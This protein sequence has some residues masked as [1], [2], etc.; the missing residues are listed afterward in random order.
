MAEPILKFD[1][2]RFQ[3]TAD[4]LGVAA[5]QLP[6]AFSRAMN[7]SAFAARQDLISAWPQ[8]VQSKNPG[9]IRWASGVEP[10]IKSDLTVR[11]TDA[12]AAGKELLQPLVDG[13]PDNAQGSRLA[14]PV[15]GQ[16]RGAR[17]ILPSQW[18]RNIKGAFRKGDAIYT[19]VGKGRNKRVKLLYVLKSSVPVPKQVPFRQ[20]FADNMTREMQQRAP[21]AKLDAMKTAPKK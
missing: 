8:Y 10:A 14:V 7:Q 2:S 1:F 13:G 12:R 17:A 18:P 4:R 19:V 9:F 15:S 21:A 5:Q 3:R 6:Y 11:I 20:I 16:R